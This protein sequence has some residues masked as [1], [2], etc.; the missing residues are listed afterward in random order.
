VTDGK[1]VEWLSVDICGVVIS[2]V[3]VILQWLSVGISVGWCDR[4][5][6]GNLRGGNRDIR[7]KRVEGQKITNLWTAPKL[8]CTCLKMRIL[9]KS[10]LNGP[11]ITMTLSK[12]RMVKR[13][14]CGSRRK[15]V[16]AAT[17]WKS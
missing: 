15:R 10:P 6:F 11:E 16:D 5:R 9:K 7:G 14:L 4:D 2:I 12:S 1:S 3:T 8:R 13:N 17:S